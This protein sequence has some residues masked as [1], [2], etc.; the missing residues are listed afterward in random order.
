MKLL[1]VL[2]G[3]AIAVGCSSQEA[4]RTVQPA[5]ERPAAAEQP[6]AV[7]RRSSP[8]LLA[9][10][11]VEKGETLWGI[12]QRYYGSSTQWRQISS[13]NPDLDPGKGIKVGQQIRIPKFVD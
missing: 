6:S 10:H 5:T 9:L 7:E 1:I 8:G 11:T 3:L 12:A 4:Q 2:A 13:A